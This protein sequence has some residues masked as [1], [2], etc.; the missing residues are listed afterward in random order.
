MTT[1]RANPR[2]YSVLLIFFTTISVGFNQSLRTKSISLEEKEYS[3]KDLIETLES[4]SNLSFNFNP[5]DLTSTIS[6]DKNQNYSIQQLLDKLASANSLQY[7]INKDQVIL[8]QRP[9]EI[10]KSSFTI[11]GYIED[12]ESKERLI[13]SHILDI[14]QSKGTIT[15]EH[16]FFSLTVKEGELD[17]LASYI[18]YQ[19]VSMPIHHK[20][21][22]TIIIG[23]R[24]ATYINEIEILGRKKTI[25]ERSEMSTSSLTQEQMNSNPALLGENDLL[26]TLESLPGVT[27]VNNIN[28]GLIVRGGGQD[29]NL[30][31]LD[32]VSI[33]NISHLFGIF[34]IFNSDV[35]KASSLIKGAFPARYGG[36]LSSIL[37]IRM[38]EGDLE[39]IHGT[40]SINL[41]A[42]KLTLQGPLANG[43][44][45]FV[46]SGRR[47]YAD[48]LIKPFIGTSDIIVE[49][50]NR[51]IPEFNFYDSNIKLQHII[52]KKHRL[53]LSLYNG[54]DNYGFESRNNLVYSRNKISWG[55][56]LGSLRWNWEINNKL[57]L[58]TSINYLQYD[59]M[60]DYELNNELNTTS[61]LKTVYRS[62]IQD[63]SLRLNF[64]F[65][66]NPEHYIRFGFL[67]IKHN[68]KPGESSIVEQKIETTLDTFINRKNIEA[69]E[70]NAYIEDDFKFENL[71]INAGIHVS[72]F[73]VEN[74]L[75]SSLQPRISLNYALSKKVAAKASYSK[76]TQFNYL[77]TSETSFFISDLWVTST[78]KIKPQNS[79]QVAGGLAFSPR[80]DYE[81]SI[82]SY[83]KYMKNVLSFKQ[84]IE[85]TLGSNNTDWESELTQ[86]TGTSYGLEVFS[87]KKEGRF[88]GWI[89]YA[90]SWNT[91]Q[92]DTINEGKTFP[93]KY[94]SRHQ[95][96]IVGNYQFSKKVHASIQW[97]YATGNYTTIPTSRAPTSISISPDT[98]TNPVLINGTDIINQRNNYQFSD[99]HRLDFSI[100]FTKQKKR[101][102][103]IWSFGLYNAYNNRNPLYIRTG[104]GGNDMS[105]NPIKQIEEVSLFL[106]IPSISYRFE[107]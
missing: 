93:Y 7:K 85:N 28:S 46:I 36:R 95:L 25:T 105:G 59:H 87:R 68:Y 18:G 3:P 55:N 22:T 73:N 27:T 40:G 78:S 20:K 8:F 92:F 65:V 80:K 107:F 12:F 9:I 106:T 104:F 102:T 24:P 39:Q 5:A 35:V 83:Y 45:S 14:N 72:A 66:P 33:Y 34:S 1:L 19:D 21:D 101:H 81:L 16:G 56:K 38:Y 91:R 47:S 26:R 4:Q 69:T 62:G 52:N 86:G 88:N 48:L 98:P 63:F 94:D 37:D 70:V 79:W 75:Y 74:N 90:L 2:I 58:N 42:S 89:S 57:F 13:G 15:N 41:I 30:V 17:L 64:D 103:R 31:L 71:T 96:S 60:F 32:G 51:I 97:N 61:Q 43:K 67:A 100:S 84:G 54:K 23:L 49:N 99:S 44:T 76:M 53:F 10:I 11:N 50:Q 82:E 29:Q 77:V 6:I